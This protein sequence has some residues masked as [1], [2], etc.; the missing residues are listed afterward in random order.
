LVDSSSKL[1]VV[2]LSCDW[3]IEAVSWQV[4]GCV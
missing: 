4:I 2:E 3:L 1:T